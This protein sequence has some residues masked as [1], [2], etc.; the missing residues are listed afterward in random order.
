MQTCIFIMSDEKRY[1]FFNNK[2]YYNFLYVYGTLTE[3]ITTVQANLVHL[4]NHPVET[5]WPR[6]TLFR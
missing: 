3:W 5:L 6:D 2:N 1:L 4:K